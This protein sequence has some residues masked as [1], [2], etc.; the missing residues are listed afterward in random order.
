MKKEEALQHFKENYV[1]EKSIEKLL[2]LE[3]Y[4]NEHKDELALD[5]MESIKEICVKIKDM[6]EENKKEKIGYITYS[7]L[8]TEILEKNY[9]YTIE[10]FNGFW[11]FDK[12]ECE[13]KY[14]VSWAFKFLDE[15]WTELEQQRKVYMNLILAADVEKIILKE[16][17]NYNQYI[18]TLARYAAEKIKD[19][20]EFESVEKEEELEIRVGEYMD[21]S[22]VVYKQDLRKKDSK[23]IKEWLEEKLE[24]KYTYEV[25]ENLDLSQGDYEGIDLRHAVV[26]GSDFSNSSMK[27]SILIGTKFNNS[28]LNNVDFS[29]CFINGGDFTNSKL[30]N[31]IFENVQGFSGLGDK[32]I[33]EMPGYAAVNFKGAD[34][35]GASFQ[36]AVL[37]G[38][39]FKGA[40]LKKV[41]FKG[42]YLEN[43]VFLKEDLEEINLDE[44]Q[45]KLIILAN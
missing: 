10:A 24:Y 35:E 23:E 41:N 36:N 12:K 1:R 3:I 33:W 28:N 43:A 25:L 22:E 44:G 2:A 32:L 39:L 16:A 4:F 21:F 42:A 5:F 17:E 9:I 40:N 11:F 34:L 19:L 45:R 15:L 8:R 30:K 38:A 14:D 13:A 20:K 18:V 6:Q 29:Q 27:D 26:S 37:T 31:A 7:M